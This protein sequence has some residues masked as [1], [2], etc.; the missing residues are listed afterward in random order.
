MSHRRC[1]CCTDEVLTIPTA[2]HRNLT[3]GEPL[4]ENNML[5]AREIMWQCLDGDIT[6][7]TQETITHNCSVTTA[8]IVTRG[9]GAD[10]GN[11]GS[12]QGRLI[13][14]VP[15]DPLVKNFAAMRIIWTGQRFDAFAHK[16]HIAAGSI[17]VYGG[18][19]KG[20]PL[21]DGQGH[22]TGGITPQ[23]LEPRIHC[24]ACVRSGGLLFC[25]LA[26]PSGENGLNGPPQFGAA[27]DSC[28]DDLSPVHQYFW[29]LEDGV[30]REATTDEL[31][32][33][34]LTVEPV[35]TQIDHEV[36]FFFAFAPTYDGYSGDLLDSYTAIWNFDT[37]SLVAQYDLN[38]VAAFVDLT[39]LN[40]STVTPT[41]IS[42]VEPSDF[43]GVA[44]TLTLTT[45][46]A[47]SG[48]ALEEIELS[49]H[50]DVGYS[51]TGQFTTGGVTVD[52]WYRPCSRLTLKLDDGTNC[53]LFVQI[54]H[55]DG[56][57][58]DDGSGS[59]DDAL[60]AATA[61]AFS[62]AALRD[63]KFP[64]PINS[65]TRLSVEWYGSDCHD[66]ASQPAGGLVIDGFF[67]R[68]AGSHPTAPASSC[69]Q[70]V[71][72][73]QLTWMTDCYSLDPVAIG[74][75]RRITDNYAALWDGVQCSLTSFAPDINGDC[76]VGHTSS[77]NKACNLNHMVALGLNVASGTM[78]FVG[79]GLPYALHL[80]FD[81]SAP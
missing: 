81:I 8:E 40:L 62:G 68:C 52:V 25:W 17:H 80:Y 69:V 66:A 38:C 26:A 32:T 54:D 10:D 73:N 20:N 78:E 76:D 9:G 79:T 12:L 42:N 29:V 60:G 1:C 19:K 67:G 22:H 36:G 30:F 47:F 77:F 50:Y 53:P 39:T 13:D 49:R 46:G 34:G 71:L 2:V 21:V 23:T 18:E 33:N 75:R 16:A 57:S 15:N 58:R 27:R 6:G 35:S 63:V 64:P 48:T 3:T 4:A 14:I 11:P 31:R 45:L 65:N 7:L 55:E 44:A 28:W 5:D 37:L 24:G 51:Y 70:G 43:H 61:P 59:G 74:Y 72:P 41:G 56:Y